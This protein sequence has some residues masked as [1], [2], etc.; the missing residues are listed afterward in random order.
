MTRWQS[1]HPGRPLLPFNGGIFGVHIYVLISFAMCASVCAARDVHAQKELY[2]P[3][4]SIYHNLSTIQNHVF[5]IVEKNKKYMKLIKDYKSRENIPQLLLHITN[6]EGSNTVNVNA[7]PVPKVQVLLSYG[8]HAR[9]FLPIESL[10]HFL[11]NLTN[12]LHSPTTSPA[13]AYAWKLLTEVD[14]YIISVANPDGRRHV[15]KTKNY[16]WRGTGTGVD[17]NRNF[18]WE[19]ALKGSS[20]DPLDE[21]FRGQ[22]AFSGELY[23]GF[24]PY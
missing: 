18:D 5:K 7:V 20:N 6:F 11:H 13:Y 1:Y 9:E 15:E 14:L 24:G 22:N 8:E 17:L 3:D 4:Y 10:F 21:E 2:T 19:F 12:C 23:S 16:C